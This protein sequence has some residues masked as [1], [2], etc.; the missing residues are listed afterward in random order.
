MSRNTL[1][2]ICL[3]L[4][5]AGCTDD[6]VNQS[7]ISSNRLNQFTVTSI[8]HGEA[9][10]IACVGLIR[11]T[12]NTVVQLY[13]RDLSL[14]K[15]IDL[16]KNPEFTGNLK[17]TCLKED[18]WLI[19]SFKEGLIPSLTIY[20]TNTNFEISHRYDFGP[21]LDSNYKA[22]VRE[23]HQLKN[24]DYIAALDTVVT[25]PTRTEFGGVRIMRFDNQ[26][27]PKY[28][29][30][31]FSAYR[32]GHYAPRI[33][34]LN[35]ESIF[36]ALGTTI[37]YSNGIRS[38]ATVGR[39]DKDGNILS[40]SLL[41]PA[42]TRRFIE[43]FGLVV[44]GNAVVLHSR[45]NF[46]TQSF[47]AM[48]ASTGKLINEVTLDN[49]EIN[50]SLTY[51]C[52]E[53]Y[54]PFTI[55]LFKSAESNTMSTNGMTDGNLLFSKTAKQIY[56]L[57]MS[58]NLSTHRKFDMVLPEFNEI[59]SYRQLITPNNRIIVGVSY[60]YKDASFFTLHEYSSD[61]LVVSR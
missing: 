42:V 17:V 35:D 3:F 39:I 13:N 61:G 36:Y 43:P 32:V 41:N 25:G 44:K 26:L 54:Y 50:H 14:K 9:D 51:G 22:T 38:D 27:N 1:F 6:L 18:G 52:F 24:G 53:N 59:Y 29:L 31:D 12:N 4:V 15:S 47:I 10:Q 16:S 21:N 30:S 20:K 8:Q 49:S 57:E 48:N 28:S 33:L 56:F 60:E 46:E 45:L 34:E 58:A 23:L 40:N 19:S 5:F 11:Q 2:S 7:G 37:A 55:E